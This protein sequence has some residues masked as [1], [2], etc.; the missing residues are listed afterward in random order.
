MGGGGEIALMVLLRYNQ[1][2]IS[3][4]QIYFSHKFMERYVRA[5]LHILSSTRKVKKGDF[6][7]AG[8]VVSNFTCV[9]EFSSR[10]SHLCSLA[11]N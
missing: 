5:C 7:T 3:K 4:H 2:Y 9:Q 10:T 6:A 8:K 1:N 11:Y